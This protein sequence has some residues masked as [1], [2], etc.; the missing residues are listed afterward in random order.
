MAHLADIPVPPPISG[1]ITIVGVCGSGKSTLASRLR[2]EGWD[3]RECQQEHS[4]ILDMWRRISRPQVLVLLH[5]ELQ[6][7]LSRDYMY[8]TPQLYQD[9]LAR[10]AGA[11]AHAA[12][13]IHTD[14]LSAGQVFIY[15]VSYLSL[16]RICSAV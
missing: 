12:I 4:Y 1:R 16:H 14:Y 8:M 3:A 2:R 5:A 9:E 15:V 7:I 13:L 6:T 10:L 11:F